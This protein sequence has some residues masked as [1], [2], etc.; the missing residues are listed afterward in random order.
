MAVQA[1][2]D[3]A[4]GTDKVTNTFKS[5]G[6]E[7]KQLT[8]LAEDHNKQLAKLKQFAGQNL[9]LSD[10][11]ALLNEKTEFLKNIQN[12]ANELFSK[13]QKF[14][15]E[16]N[17]S[18]ADVGSA[19]IS[20]LVQALV[21]SIEECRKA[22]KEVSEDMAKDW[23]DLANELKAEK[24]SHTKEAGLTDEQID[25][26]ADTLFGDEKEGFDIDGPAQT[27]TLD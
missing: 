25:T 4:N 22:I 12:K 14:A 2:V 15:V 23:K 16:N 9:T 19:I 3:Q 5:L 11:L 6:D 18:G 26:I 13:V 27:L 8:K 21:Q 10:R 24:G 7:A 20:K 17:F 1:D